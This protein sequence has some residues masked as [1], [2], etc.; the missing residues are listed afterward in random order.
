MDIESIRTLYK[1]LDYVTPLRRDCGKMCSSKCCKGTSHDGMLLFPGEEA[2]FQNNNDFN[3]YYDERYGCNCVSCNGSCSRE[4]RPI[5]CRI[6]PYFIYLKDDDKNT[7]P[8]V[9]SD[10]RAIDFCPLLT[11]ENKIS[12]EFLRTLR[13]VASKMCRDEEIRKFLVRM[14]ELLTDFKGL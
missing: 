3:I 4:M 7:K 13:I 11:K 8:V 9:A 6:F 1:S 2:V 10:V 5:S 14:T 12:K